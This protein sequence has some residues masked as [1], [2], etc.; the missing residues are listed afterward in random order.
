MIAGRA[1]AVAMENLLRF[2]WWAPSAWGGALE[3]FGLPLSRAFVVA[4]LTWYL[5][6]AARTAFEHATLKTGADANLRLLTGR[7]V[8]LAIMTVGTVTVLDNFGVPLSTVVTVVG[9]VGLGISLALQDI[10][11][12]FF[13]GT[14]L[15]FERPFRLGD[16]I[17]VKE[18]RGTVETIGIRTTTLR[19]PEHVHILIPNAMVFSEVVVDRTHERPVVP[20]PSVDEHS[21]D[22]GEDGP[23][24]D[25]AAATVAGTT[26]AGANGATSNGATAAGSIGATTSFA[27]LSRTV[28]EKLA[29]AELRL[30]ELRPIELKLA[31]LPRSLAAFARCQIRRFR[32]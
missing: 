13:A 8:Y 28:T 20:K 2:Q 22:R 11:K 5:A 27:V 7:L 6:R 1:E 21:A 12:N 31:E 4:V 18:Y 25:K 32:V 30:A 16:V 9:V 24:R 29:V 14:Y 23:D 26:V 17:S 19:T 3:A 10:L 15:L